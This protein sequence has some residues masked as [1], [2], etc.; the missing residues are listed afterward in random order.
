MKIVTLLTDFGYKD[1]YVAAMKGVI[2]SICPDA[3]IIDVS[4]GVPSFDII[5]ASYILKA[6]Y[7]YFPEKTVH[8]VVVDPG[9]GTSRKAIVIET[10]KYFFVGPDNGVLIP[11]AM[12]DGIRR[13]VEIS[14]KY[15]RCRV[16]STFHGRD[17]FAPVAAYIA[18]GVRLEEIGEVL[19]SYVAPKFVEPEFTDGKVRA[20][21]IYIDKFG[22]AATN[23]SN[24]LV[25][26][27]GLKYGDK[28][29]VEIKGQTIVLPFLP[30]FGYVGEGEGLLL[31]NSEG[32]LELAVNL[33]SAAEKYG[34]NVGDE[35][36]IYV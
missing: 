1:H 25:K 20:K 14:G 10:K 8:V 18:C 23:V 35:M 3:Q 17:I 15:M 21:I 28:V 4:H 30:S 24:E 13:V 32:Y 22:N 5:S 26:K 31:I 19:H 6:A 2:L 29:K 7:K 27:M 33:G 9:V 12:D 34:L 36:L 11:A 16:S